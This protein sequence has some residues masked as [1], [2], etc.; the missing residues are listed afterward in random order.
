MDGPSVNQSFLRLLQ[1]ELVEKAHSFFNIGSCL[2]H[3]VQNTFK[4]V[5]TVLKPAIDL[6]LIATDL[7][8]FFKRSAARRQDYKMVEEITETTVWYLKKHVDLRWLS[9]DRSVVRILDQMQNL[10]G[11]FLVQLPRQKGFNGS[12]GLLKNDRYQ[13]I[14]GMLKSKEVEVCMSFT[15][16]LASDF[17]HFMVPLQ[18]SAPMIHCLYS[19]CLH[20][21]CAVMGKVIRE[22]HT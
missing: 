5:L 12:N 10:R 3:I 20:L 14:C 8:F 17:S 9:I 4:K 21:V 13:R 6:D 15:I 7:H 22:D 18:T 1:L 16:Y 2:L 19:M 11:Y